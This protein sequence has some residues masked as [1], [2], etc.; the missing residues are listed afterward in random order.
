MLA[1]FEVHPARLTN[2][3]QGNTAVTTRT[4]PAWHLGTLGRVWRAEPAPGYDV[5]YPIAAH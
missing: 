1:A 5:I 3:T 4:G 2:T